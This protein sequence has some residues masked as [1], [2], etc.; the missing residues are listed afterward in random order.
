MSEF[1]L[2]K[3]QLLIFLIGYPLFVIY[4]FRIFSYPQNIDSFADNIIIESTTHD[5]TANDQMGIDTETTAAN[6]T[7]S[8]SCHARSR[9]NG[10]D[11]SNLDFEWF[12]RGRPVSSSY[13][14]SSSSSSSGSQNHAAVTF[15]KQENT[16]TM[17]SEDPWL[18]IGT[19]QC[20]VSIASPT[21]ADQ[22]HEVKSANAHILA[23]GRLLLETML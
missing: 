7:I 14:Y 8:L 5:F 17:V 16:L 13:I 12:F 23:R 10:S 19:V 3:N 11:H 21:G 18:L 20:F 1:P 9:L 22:L 6:H 15:I 2:L 4:V